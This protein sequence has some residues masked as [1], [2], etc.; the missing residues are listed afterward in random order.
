MDKKE[1]KNREDKKIKQREKI[2]PWW[3]SLKNFSYGEKVKEKD[4]NDPSY[5]R[6]KKNQKLGSFS[7]TVSMED[8]YSRPQCGESP[9][10]LGGASCG[11]SKREAR[12]AQRA[13]DK[14]EFRKELLDE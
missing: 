14:E 4:K 12:R 10:N 13:Y 7:G 3:F 11:E 8:A 2:Y 6:I 9:W 5:R 1:R